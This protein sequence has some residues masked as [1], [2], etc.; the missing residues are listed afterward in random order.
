MLAGFDMKTNIR[1][2]ADPMTGNKFL[3]TTGKDMEEK[4]ILPHSISSHQKELSQNLF[5]TSEG[6]LLPKK[7]QRQLSS[8]SS[9]HLVNSE[10]RASPVSNKKIKP[11]SSLSKKT[12]TTISKRTQNENKNLVQKQ[13]KSQA[14]ES[15]ISTSSPKSSQLL[16]SDAKESRIIDETKHPDS[17]WSSLLSNFG[18]SPDKIP[19]PLPACPEIPPGLQGRISLNLSILPLAQVEAKLPRVGQGGE[20][21]PLNCSSNHQVAV[22]VPYRDRPTQLAVF[23]NN[24]HPML[25]KQQ[26]HYRIYLVNQTDSNTFNRAMLMNVG[27]VEAMKDHNWTCAIFHDVDLLPEDDRNLYNCPDQPRHLSV[28]VDKFK[29]RLPYKGIFG[30]ATAVRADQFRCLPI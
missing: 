9:N 3:T 5:A 13:P 19:A 20:S 21:K 23:L 8:S 2:G 14:Q 16:I 1:E 30:G 22:I 29:Y 12:K 11:E 15:K 6:A 27:F 18:L 24:L 25:I 28:A 7:S 26:L 17:V 4:K 10:T